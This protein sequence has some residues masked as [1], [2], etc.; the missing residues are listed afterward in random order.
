L[1]CFATELANL[2][3][4]R[5]NCRSRAQVDAQMRLEARGGFFLV[6]RAETGSCENLRA[7]EIMW[8]EI[9]L[10]WCGWSLEYGSNEEP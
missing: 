1:T 8:Y 6:R 3:R 10:R 5:R 9:E 7:P 2:C 4:S